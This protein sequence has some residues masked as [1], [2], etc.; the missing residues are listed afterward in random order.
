MRTAPPQ[1]F[2]LESDGNGATF[3]TSVLGC[4]AGS[5]TL[6]VNGTLTVNR[7]F[8]D[9]I[10][11]GI[12][13]FSTN[14]Y[15]V[16]NVSSLTLNTFTADNGYQLFISTNSTIANTLD[17]ITLNTRGFETD[18]ISTN[19]FRGGIYTK[20]EVFVSTF[21]SIQTNAENFF[22]NY[23]T[24][25][26]SAQINNS[27]FGITNFDN[28]TVLETT[29]VSTIQTNSVY[30]D[31]FTAAQTSTLDLRVSTINGLT[32]PPQVSFS[33][34][35]EASTLFARDAISTSLT[36]ADSISTIRL[37]A[38]SVYTDEYR[39][40]LISTNTVNVGILNTQTLITS[41]LQ[42]QSTVTL[43][44][45]FRSLV[46]KSLS[47]NQIQ[48]LSTS[49]SN[50]IMQ[51][52]LTT[53]AYA[54][55]AQFTSANA[56]FVSTAN[57]YIG[58]YS[59]NDPVDEIYLSSLSLNAGSLTASSIQT[60]YL[61]SGFLQTSRT[62]GNQFSGQQV[63][64]GLLFTDSVNVSSLKLESFSTNILTTTEFTALTIATDF[65]S[66]GL[67]FANTGSANTWITEFLS[68]QTGTIANPTSFQS[69]FIEN[70]YTSSITVPT[71]NIESI[72]SLYV[73]TNTM[74]ISYTNT[75]SLEAYSISSIQNYFSSISAFE[76]KA[77]T[78][79]SLTA[80]SDAGQFDSVSI[81]TLSS[82]VL[83]ATSGNS[84]FAYANEVYTNIL[85]TTD[86]V[87]PIF[88][89]VSLSS[90]TAK[91]E[92]VIVS[93]LIANEVSTSIL[94]GQTLT[95]SDAFI[96]QELYTS[97]FVGSFYNVTTFK[98]G[99]ATIEDLYVS[100][101]L[102]V[103]YPPP[104]PFP[105]NLEISSATVAETTTAST[106]NVE[107]LS[108][109]QIYIGLLN[110]KSTIINSLSSINSYFDTALTST[111]TVDLISA[112]TVYA[113]EANLKELNTF[114]FST[115]ELY[116][117]VG[118]VSS[119]NINSISSGSIVVDTIYIS[120]LIG[121]NISTN[122]L[123]GQIHDG[124]VL[125]ANVVSSGILNIDDLYL[126]KFSA[127]VL[128]TIFLSTQDAYISSLVADSVIAQSTIFTSSI[129]NNLTTTF[130]SSGVANLGLISLDSASTDTFSTSAL[131][132]SS[133]LFSTINTIY[134][135]TSSVVATNA[136]INQASVGQ[137]S[138][139]SLFG[140]SMY[141]S[142]LITKTISS[143]S[144]SLQ[145]AYTSSL[146]L[147][148]ISAGKFV[149]LETRISS[150]YVDQLSTG[151]TT[152]RGFISSLYTNA[153]SISSFNAN[154][155]NVSSLQVDKLSTSF[156][157]IPIVNISSLHTTYV[158]EPIT[159]VDTII[160][161]STINTD[162]YKAQTLNANYISTNSINTQ[163][164]SAHTM[165]VYGGNTLNVSGSS[166]FTGIVQAQAEFQADSITASSLVY[167]TILPQGAIFDEFNSEVILASTIA[168]EEVTTKGLSAYSIE[169]SRFE[170][171][172]A[173]LSS[174]TTP[175]ISS[176][177][178]YGSNANISSLSAQRATYLG[179]V[180]SVPLI[181]SQQTFSM[182]ANIQ[183]IETDS[184]YTSSLYTNNTL[185]SNINT[186]FLSAASIIVPS[187]GVTNTLNANSI[188]T[189]RIIF[190]G[191]TTAFT[192][193]FSLSSIEVRAPLTNTFV[194]SIIFSEF[195]TQ[196]IRTTF[197]NG[198]AASSLSISTNSIVFGAGRF[199]TISTNELSTTSLFVNNGIF[200]NR[201][202]TNSIS[203]GLIVGNINSIGTSQVL[204]NNL[205]TATISSQSIFVNSLNI[206]SL[207]TIQL[208]AQHLETV[209]V[210]A[211]FISTN[212]YTSIRNT[213]Q[214]VNTNFIS[215]GILNGPGGRFVFSSIFTSSLVTNFGTISNL[216]LQDSLFSRS[217]TT[218]DSYGGT[219]F[220]RNM[221]TS[222]ISSGSVFGL[223]NG[224]SAY[225][226]T[227]YLST[228]RVIGAT[229]S[230]FYLGSLSSF[231]I[232]TNRVLVSSG[233]TSD[234]LNVGQISTNRLFAGDIF[235]GGISTNSLN[236][237]S[238]TIE[239]VRANFISTSNLSTGTIEN[240]PQTATFNLT[241]TSIISSGTIAFGGSPGLNF[242]MYTT[243][244][245][246][247]SYSNIDNSYYFDLFTGL[248]GNRLNTNSNGYT[249]NFSNI[250][251]ATNNLFGTSTDRSVIWTG[252]FYASQTGSYTFR[253]Q[254]TDFMRFWIGDSLKPKSTY[255]L[256]SPKQISGLW[257][258]LDASDNNYVRDQNS[259]VLTPGPSS[260][261]R[262]WIDKSGNGRNASNITSS[263]ATYPYYSNDVSLGK[264][265]LYFDAYGV[266]DNQMNISEFTFPF[267]YYGVV[268]TNLTA[269]YKRS[270]LCVGCNSS[271]SAHRT[272]Y[273]DATASNWLIQSNIGTTY[274]A[275][276]PLRETSKD[277]RLVRILF[278]NTTNSIWQNGI[279]LVNCNATPFPAN[280][281][282]SSNTGSFRISGDTTVINTLAATTWEGNM[283]E[284][285]IYNRALSDPERYSVENYLGQKW[286]IST[287]AGPYNSNTQLFGG[288]VA[289][290]SYSGSCN[291]NA[292]TYYPIRLQYA[293][294]TGGTQ[295]FYLSIQPPGTTTQTC[296]ITVNSTP[297]FKSTLTNFINLNTQFSTIQTV[298]YGNFQRLS[299]LFLSTA[300]A[301]NIDNYTVG[302]LSTNAVSSIFTN[303]RVFNASNINRLNFLST[304]ILQASNVQANIIIT[305]QLSS[306]NISSFAMFISSAQI[307]SFVRG[308]RLTANE[309]TVL[310]NISTLSTFAT[311]INT[312]I[313]N[314]SSFSSFTGIIKPGDIVYRNFTNYNAQT[315]PGSNTTFTN[316]IITN[317]LN[318]GV[319]NTNSYRG[320]QITNLSSTTN[321][322]PDFQLGDWGVYFRPAP[323][324]LFPN[325]LESLSN[326][327]FFNST[328]FVHR[329]SNAVGINT[330]DVSS[331]ALNINGSIVVRTAG[332]AYKP[333]PGSW[334]G[335]SDKR[336]KTDITLADLDRCYEIN[337]T[338]SLFD[339]NLIDEYRDAFNVSNTRITGFLAQHVSSFFPNAVTSKKILWLDDALTLNTYQ[340]QLANYG[341][342]QKLISSFDTINETI[343]TFIYYPNAIQYSGQLYSLNESL[344]N[345]Y[346]NFKNSIAEKQS[347]LE[348]TTMSFQTLENSFT[349][350]I[351]YA[352]T[353][354]QETKDK[355]I[356]QQEPLPQEPL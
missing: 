283:C 277:Y 19:Y 63:S 100:T 251:T 195:S 267:D 343:S 121:E 193:T 214:T 322:L 289:N 314:V 348:G 205:S 134:L 260:R 129:L 175:F 59:T 165:V 127:R 189:T 304:G 144:L 208:Y 313:L 41:T 4:N 177:T 145:N 240:T 345:S 111:L 299:T 266:T 215:A 293:R 131:V 268:K 331:F 21:S 340:A 218:A 93:S 296:N 250:N 150:I 198:L 241:S 310:G 162:F 25:T 116:G 115:F 138:S 216:T 200:Q 309:L 65:I 272:I 330:Q 229:S 324:N 290:T 7:G 245:A 135:S 341:S 261:V 192:S 235:V 226:S 48:S 28:A 337:K 164:I 223:S 332:G 3:W 328:L 342:L 233:V 62:T 141:V 158:K 20:P 276:S 32:Y 133:I 312:Q 119:M 168:A 278:T 280:T 351:S 236:V 265:S 120:S 86:I 356:Q 78:I 352:S 117:D 54:K 190:N 17:A 91:A 77:E 308:Q 301:L 282:P 294:A 242:Q 75:S 108:A 52:L 160:V 230:E 292:N 143:T 232:S 221:T 178:F 347:T 142:S 269:G 157:T 106:I 8:I 103:S 185:T 64:T 186:H 156:A 262:Y 243:S 172:Y 140:N 315:F 57:L 30:S 263:T 105:D 99:V 271:S 126:E 110:S 83:S 36:N 43:T 176:S 300:T 98:A 305:D 231:T 210:N 325:R 74:E 22:I 335:G 179:R 58:E 248:Y 281:L 107:Y 42:T 38:N 237:G 321:S 49:G 171:Q 286:N 257:T 152:T 87:Y 27:F 227:N 81:N 45:Q 70:L 146:E 212:F 284:I 35:L 327:Y 89:G 92:Q 15:P 88:N 2:V 159:D 323:N 23:S 329:L 180:N 163:F 1:D 96:N 128:S 222:T 47:T 130:I 139:Y 307:S 291:L 148:S 194:S 254:P 118:E 12:I 169:A 297:A 206:S 136:F 161:N 244:F 238:L 197:A 285:L 124:L 10:S 339:Y 122:S 196:S 26:K 202:D 73:S 302:G 34:N 166:I 311:N 288:S 336:V 220:L 355:K 338:L 137:I 69:T 279:P 68:S 173:N 316:Q 61:S 50:A 44:A 13:N 182:L 318:T 211:N 354:L 46:G 55:T 199:T 273:I 39:A 80:F 18:I 203:T 181:S 191:M 264:P 234:G 84:V 333:S 270:L 259:N 213:I 256:G 40:N 353:L 219:I 306:Q 101:L 79:S 303:I 29:R 319:I 183:T 66:S 94:I 275:N 188:S 239:N 31:R 346:A 76:A 151:T 295:A 114:Y 249:T 154:V 53:Q 217:L 109:A 274:L 184:L 334:T 350:L 33:A 247:A 155:L 246:Q 326:G 298:Q 67:L 287:I 11:A 9:Y 224:I 5:S 170:T 90:I 97:S 82:S 123:Q 225:L 209:S 153:L 167:V 204:T 37:F 71:A 51:S 6:F 132:T 317:E 201:L 95:S 320:I 207:S 147:D 72:S 349:S 85:E 258:W 16:I 113:N 112:N 56:R 174:L 14:M 60:R 228:G 187:N 104:L 125:N 255:Y 344:E 253:S 252:F 24:V 102:D 149:T